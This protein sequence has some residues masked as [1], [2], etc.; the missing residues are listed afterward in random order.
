MTDT[1]KIV[2]VI[3]PVVDIRFSPDHLPAIRNAIHINVSDGYTMTVQVLPGGYY[4]S[5]TATGTASVTCPAIAYCLPL[6]MR[7]PRRIVSSEATHL[8]AHQ[9]ECV[10]VRSPCARMPCAVRAMRSG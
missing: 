4:N 8:R 9:A 1:G 3:G 5:D 2:Q 10:R 7:A 6:P